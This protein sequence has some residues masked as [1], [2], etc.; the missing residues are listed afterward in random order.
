MKIAIF[1]IGA[2]GSLLGVRLSPHADV[3]LVGQWSEQRNA[4]SDSGLH[5]QHPDSSTSTTTLNVTNDPSDIGAVDVV[6]IA[7]KSPK[8]EAACIG[9]AKILK[10]DGLA[11]TMQNG[12]GRIE[13]LAQYFGTARATQ[14]V[15]AQGAYMEGAGRLIHAG[16]G[17]T[18]IAASDHPML[19]SVVDLLRNA[20]LETEVMDDLTSIV[21]GKLVA[22]AA[23]NPL[24]A[25]LKVK[26]GELLNSKSARLLMRRAAREVGQ[27]AA[28]KG[29]KLPFESPEAWAEQVA[30]MTANNR[31]S[32]LQDVLRGARTEVDAICGAVVREAKLAGVDTPVNVTLCRM[33]S[34]IQDT[35]GSRVA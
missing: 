34:A 5:I 7:T 20:G 29:I 12:L 25:V 13:V 27:L 18:H 2:L 10:Q 22:N 23:I 17:P 6:I 26:N 24:T 14:A 15:T 28:K 31:S 21:W 35:E 9:G 1:G 4:L 33:V 30:T 32:M 19:A 11:L 8:T 3:T 16:E